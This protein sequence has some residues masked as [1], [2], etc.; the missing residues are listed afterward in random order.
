MSFEAILG[1]VA[2]AAAGTCF[3]VAVVLYALEARRLP[4]EVRPSASFLRRLLR[5]PRW[6]GAVALDV[7]GWPLQ[8][9]ALALAPLTLVQPALALGLP[10]LLL[11]G[12]R[13]L[14][15]RIGRSEVVATGS[16]VAGVVAI[17]LAAPDHTASHTSGG[18]LAVALVGL[19]AVALTPYAIRR[20]A[21]SGLL[22][23]GA[24]CA[25][26][27]TGLSSRLIA[28]GLAH[29]TALA[30]LALAAGTA[31]VGLTGLLSET[32]A[33]QRRAATAVAP[34][35]YGIQVAMPVA[36][37]PVVLDE[38]W[39]STPGGGAVIV[40]GLLAVVAG[41]VKLGRSR[42]VGGLMARAGDPAAK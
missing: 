33:L 9:G 23:L 15:E 2:A 19:G 10:V 17:G 16:I 38:R 32:A 4:A 26:A 35:I 18:R 27:W 14:G 12:A 37:A 3:D 21:P 30:V 29:G 11:L 22:V 20:G 40:A 6:V 13:I 36:L 42:T 1:L 41:A 25:Y 8:L 5:R 28:D 39:G 7:L 24:G 31:V 34:A